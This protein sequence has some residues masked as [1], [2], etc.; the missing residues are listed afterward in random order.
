MFTFT[1]SSPSLR[2]LQGGYLF[3]E[4]ND[5]FYQNIVRVSYSDKTPVIH[6]L[7]GSNIFKVSEYFSFKLFNKIFKGHSRLK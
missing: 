2:G 1:F 5:P 6:Q 4:P 3:S 7:C